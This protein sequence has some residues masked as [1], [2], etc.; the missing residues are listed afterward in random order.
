MP[1]PR[2]FQIRVGVADDGGVSSERRPARWVVRVAPILLI[3]A[4][5]GSASLVGGSPNTSGSNAA[6][7]GSRDKSGKTSKTGATKQPAKTSTTLTPRS[8]RPYDKQ[9]R[10]TI[11]SLNRKW[12]VWLPQYFDVDYEKLT[13]GLYAYRSDTVTPKCDGTRLP[14]LVIRQNAFFCPEDDF[15]AW[16][17]E[18]LFPKLAE[19]HGTLLLSVVLAHEWGHAIQQRA[20]LFYEL[21]TII[22]EQQADCFAGAW[23]AGLD[24]NNPD[25][26]QLVAMRGAQLDASLAGFVEFRDIVGLNELSAGSHG[27]AFDRMRAFQEGFESGP[28]KCATYADTPPE[29]VGFAFRNLKERFRGGNLPFPELVKE[30]VA[31]LEKSSAT[32]SKLTFVEETADAPP[33]ARPQPFAGLIG[34]AVSGCRDGA[35]SIRFR[36]AA[37]K[38]WFDEFGDFAP[39]TVLSLGWASMATSTGSTAADRSGTFAADC[40]AGRWTGELVDLKRPE[41]SA[42]S[43]GDLDE[44]AQTLL[45]LAAAEKEPGRGFERVRSFRVGLMTGSCDAPSA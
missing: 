44:A 42:L 8:A 12:A 34:K 9:L 25:E 5:I 31:S 37:L 33:C 18:G 13:G 23:L 26:K 21:S 27:T 40:L 22:S 45:K 16:D 36:R 28:G 10:A 4:V 35:G 41:T 7:T 6:S 3:A 11:A 38:K 24:P 43:P 15:I 14:Y 17:D 2:A 20:D 19:A 29:L 39:A 1:L 30:T 32:S